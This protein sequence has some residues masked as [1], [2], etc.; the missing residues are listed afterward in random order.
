M[1][2]PK[3]YK[4]SEAQKRS[5]SESR[6]GMKFTDE[7]RANISAARCGKPPANKGKP[8]SEAT[9]EKLK[10][11]FA[12]RARTPYGRG[13]EHS[14]VLLEYAAIL[15]PLGYLLDTITVPIPT[16]SAYKLDFA[17]LPEKINVEIDGRT[18]RDRVEQDARRDAYMRS[19]GWKVIRIKSE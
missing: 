2:W 6:L 17:L 19:L 7:H 15:C 16:G 18:H 4:M 13:G 1:G 11:A 3:G 12:G 14:P 5:I 9:R 8:I 10:K